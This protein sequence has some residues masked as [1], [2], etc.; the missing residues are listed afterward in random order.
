MLGSGFS[1]PDGLPSL[2]Q[3]NARLCKVNEDE[4]LISSSQLAICLNGQHDGNRRINWDERLFVQD[5][6]KFYNLTVLTP[7]QAFD[8]EEFYDFYSSYI[9]K[10]SNSELIEKFC[11]EFNNAYKLLHSR[12][13]LNRI[14]DFNRTFNQLLASLLQNPNYYD[15]G[16]AGNYPPYD[17]F[18]GFM[19]EA[20]QT[21]DLKV[22][23]LNHDTLFEWMGYHLSSLFS[24]F[25]DGFAL[26]GSPY[27]GELD[28]AYTFSDRDSVH[29]TYLVKLERFINRYDKPICLYKL[30]GSVGHKLIYTQRDDEPVVRLKANYGI[31]K[32]FYEK[33]LENGDFRL[34]WLLDDVSPDYLSGAM[35][36]IGR[37]TRDPYYANL[38]KHFETNLISSEVLLIIGYGFKDAEV[39]RYL[40]D[41]Y[42]SKSKV[43][44]IIDPAK[45]ESDLIDKY[46][47]RQIPKGITQVQYKE[48]LEIIK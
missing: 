26:E 6:L 42:L 9:D 27:Y 25:T 11:Q 17:S 48:L 10:K 29:K 23:T 34:E 43:A 24:L 38:F 47:I 3:I 44:V 2:Q 39:N 40:E 33:Q 12:D 1:I 7:D 20:A 37:Y 28:Q 18:I 22:H 32:Y 5:F 35:T 4:I 19:T 41:Y 36:K 46:K 16:T 15:D 45:P 21:Y 30:H 8:Y 13:C 14:A 31:G